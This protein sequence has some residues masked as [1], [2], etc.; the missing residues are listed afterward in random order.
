M[1]A[2]LTYATYRRKIDQFLADELE[3]ISP[4]IDKNTDTFCFTEEDEEAEENK[5]DARQVF[6]ADVFFADIKREMENCEDTTAQNY[7]FGCLHGYMPKLT[8]AL[9]KKGLYEDVAS[10]YKAWLAFLHQSGA[11]GTHILRVVVDVGDKLL[12]DLLSYKCFSEAFDVYYASLNHLDR[13][14]KIR[15]NPDK[16]KAIADFLTDNASRL[17]PIYADTA[18]NGLDTTRRVSTTKIPTGFEHI[19]Y[20][21][22]QKSVYAYKDTLLKLR[23]LASDRIV[24]LIQELHPQLTEKCQDRQSGVEMCDQEGKH[25]DI[26][27]SPDNDVIHQLFLGTLDLMVEVANQKDLYRYITQHAAPTLQMLF[28]GQETEKILEVYKG[29]IAA[30]QNM[31]DKNLSAN[32][33]LDFI[34]RFGVE[35]VKGLTRR[36]GIHKAAGLLQDMRKGLGADDTLVFVTFYPADDKVAPHKPL[37]MLFPAQ[38]I[39]V[40]LDGTVHDVAVF[41]AHNGRDMAPIKDESDILRLADAVVD[42]S[43]HASTAVENKEKRIISLT[44]H[45]VGGYDFDVDVREEALIKQQILQITHHAGNLYD[46]VTLVKSNLGFCSLQRLIVH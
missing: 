44:H 3:R 34:N 20:S 28:A 35:I 13:P 42:V 32:C 18:P 29:C 8:K 6:Y 36:G 25:I 10:A 43:N 14:M 39:D 33:R 30:I 22:P 12:S 23:A 19:L 45:R 1:S 11:N 4:S 5:I 17:L 16:E 46:N 2:P 37:A 21:Y 38:G 15:L 31:T 40:T 24:P 41:F 26:K 7:T 9:M 27:F